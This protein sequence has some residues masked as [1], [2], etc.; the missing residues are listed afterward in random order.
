MKEKALRLLEKITPVNFN[1]QNPRHKSQFD[2]QTSGI[3]VSD[4]FVVIV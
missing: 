4:T 3:T 2:L 1:E